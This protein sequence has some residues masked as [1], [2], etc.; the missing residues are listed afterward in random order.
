[1]SWARRLKRVFGVEIESCARG[2]GELKDL[3]ARTSLVAASSPSSRRAICARVG[4]P[5]RR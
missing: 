1:M 2:G 3:V 5:V 4:G